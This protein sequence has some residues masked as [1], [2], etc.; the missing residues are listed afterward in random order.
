MVHFIISLLSFS[1]CPKDKNEF[2]LDFIQ[3]YASH[4]SW[5]IRE[6]VAMGIQE[7]SENNMKETLKNI[8]KMKDGNYYEK[9]AVVAGL[10]EPKLLKD[11]KTATN[12][13][14]ILFE[15]TEKLNHDNKLTDEEE[16]L[17]KALA[18]GW[19]V[20]IVHTPENGKKVFER[21]LATKKGKHIKWIIKENLKKNRLIKMDANWVKEMENRLTKAST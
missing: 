20:A 3:K 13:I 11:E 2:I 7:I 12:V 5:R 18:Y 15:I 9:R 4:K 8:V 10:C 19:S 14:N 17:R 16:S 1:R 6:A 21:L